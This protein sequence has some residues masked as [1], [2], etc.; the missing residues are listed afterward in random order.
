MSL[1]PRRVELIKSET[2]NPTPETNP[3]DKT[4]MVQKGGQAPRED[5]FLPAFA[6]DWL[7]ASPRF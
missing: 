4:G 1:S 3:N 2:R 6:V 5:A 7:G